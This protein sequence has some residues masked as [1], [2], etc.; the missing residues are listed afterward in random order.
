MLLRVYS[1]SCC[2]KAENLSFIVNKPYTKREDK[3]IK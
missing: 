2:F 1:F 3:N